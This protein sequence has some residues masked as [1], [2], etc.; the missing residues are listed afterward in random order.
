[1]AT[2][3][4]SLPNEVSKNEVVS[5][6][7]KNTEAAVNIKIANPPTQQPI[8]APN[9]PT[10]LSQQSIQQIVAG[11]QQAQ[12]STGLPS[13]DLPKNDN[14][15]TQD[16]QV[17][18]NYVPKSENTNYIENDQD[19][20]TLIQQSKNKSV[21]QDRLDILYDELQ[22]PVIVMILYFFFQLPIF[23][24]TLAKN[25]P[26]LFSRDGNP[27]F[28]GYLFKTAVFGSVFYGLT[29]LTRQI[30]EI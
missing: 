1:M 19:F 7:E 5:M 28:S 12:G 16:V 4:S 27:S 11:L 2:A 26:S 21:E 22:T 13:R 8:I 18:P 15:I 24:K 6:V 29:K 30:S 23:Q 10:E 9:A 17:Q 3:I 14:H 20:E 25:I